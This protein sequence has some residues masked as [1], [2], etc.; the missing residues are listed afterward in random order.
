VP[1]LTLLLRE[2]MLGLV[3]DTRRTIGVA[4]PQPAAVL[5]FRVG[6]AHLPWLEFTAIVSLRALIRRP[7]VVIVVTSTGGHSTG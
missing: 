5:V 6:V 1:D 2:A 7:I 3:T 4:G